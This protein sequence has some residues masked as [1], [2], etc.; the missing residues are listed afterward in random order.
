MNGGNKPG[1][2]TV[3]GVD[4]PY[5]TVAGSTAASTHAGQVLFNRSHSDT[6]GASDAQQYQID[7][8]EAK[9]LVFK[10]RTNVNTQHMSLA[11][12]TSAKDGI[13]SLRIPLSSLKNGQW[14]IIVVDLATTFPS[15][16]V[17]DTETGRYLVDSLYF[18]MNSF[19]PE[20]CIDVAYIAFVEGDLDDVDV[21]VDESK[22]LYVAGTSVTEINIG[23]GGSDEDETVEQETTEQETTEQETT[24]QETT[25]QET[26]APGVELFLSPSELATPPYKQ[27]S[28]DLE[29]MS[30]GETQF[31]RLDNFVPAG[32]TDKWGGVN[33]INGSVGVTGQYMVMKLRIGE[34][35]LNQTHLAMFIRSTG[36][37]LVEG[38]RVDVKVAED[39]E[40]HIIVID[41]SN[42]V[43]DAATYFATDSDGKYHTRY[44]QI[45]PFSNNQVGAQAD[46]YMDIA[47]IAFCDSRDELGSIISEETY[48]WSKSRSE[49]EELKVADHSCAKHTA[50]EM[51]I[52]S[53]DGVTVY[54]S[55][56][57][58]CGNVCYERKVGEQVSMFLPGSEIVAGDQ[59]FYLG[60]KGSVQ[61]DPE[62]NVIFGQEGG[63]R[64]IIWAR[65]Q[66]DCNSSTHSNQSDIYYDVGNANLLVIRLK[67]DNVDR[68]LTLSLSTTAYNAPTSVA[69]EANPD[70]YTIEGEKGIEVGDTYSL[71][72]GYKTVTIP[73]AAHVVEGEWMTCVIELEC[74]FGDAYGKES[75]ADGYVLD[76][77]M[78]D[79]TGEG[80]LGFEYMAFVEA[81]DYL[82]LGDQLG[83]DQQNGKFVVV[84]TLDGGSPK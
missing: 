14:G 51:Q 58:A 46:D 72:S 39:G 84:T 19:M 78:M 2:V 52:K 59:H 71:G 49:S 64:Q 5:G 9:Y 70:G 73:I 20:T 33:F 31:V 28:C 83:V 60:D 48:E 67:T 35:G 43:K 57:S 53:E 68:K 15:H 23:E 50:G 62:N 7:V 18:T 3:D 16:Y 44:V 22:A 80:R 25:E 82:V 10:I 75:G 74:V 6:S 42:R 26:A 21:L 61:F 29:V 1:T 56:C 45:R 55:V 81:S 11:F 38:M 17:K 34:N 41:L 4:F 8:G 79:I 12:S 36:S 69:T 40:W 63:N 76:T 77:L 27:G 54:S 66:A 37:G 13:G 47:Y 24:E 65:A 30:E 32:S